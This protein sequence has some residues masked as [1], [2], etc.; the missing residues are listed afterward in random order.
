[1]SSDNATPST[2]PIPSDPVILQ[3]IKDAMIEISKSKARAQGERD[4]QTQAFNDLA[5]KTGVPN[6]I[7]RKLANVIDDGIDK[8][9][10]E[11]EDLGLLANRVKGVKATE[12]IP[13]V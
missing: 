4:F 8:M 7:L 11:V 1:M 9:A 5:E 10:K 2:F 13:N 3:V 6:G 12:V